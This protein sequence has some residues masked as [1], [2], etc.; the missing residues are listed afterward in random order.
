MI[1]NKKAPD[2]VAVAYVTVVVF[3][4]LALV[5]G[6]EHAGEVMLTMY[7]RILTVIGSIVFGVVGVAVVWGLGSWILELFKKKP[8]KP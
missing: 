7:K 2:W 4:L 8:P 3:I 6:G 5:I 1:P